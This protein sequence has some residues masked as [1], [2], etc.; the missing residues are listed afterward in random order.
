MSYE[1]IQDT[2]IEGI[3]SSFANLGLNKTSGQIY[4][5]I[6]VNNRPTSLQQIVD[7]LQISKGNASINVRLLEDLGAIKKVWQKGDRKDYY[8]PHLDIWQFMGSLIYQNAAETIKGTENALET[9]I[10]MLQ[11]DMKSFTNEQRDDSRVL[12]QHLQQHKGT[13]SYSSEICKELAD[14]EGYVT[15][16]KLRTIWSMLKSQLMMKK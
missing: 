4:T 5:F 1:K 12:M 10:A 7:F 3:S 13:F 6:S 9:T 8:E 16:Q 11:S 14:F 15:L 2:L